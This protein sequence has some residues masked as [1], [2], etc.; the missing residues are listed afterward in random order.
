VCPQGR[1]P[2]CHAA[3]TLGGRRPTS[4][5]NVAAAS[6]L[7]DHPRTVDLRQADLLPHLDG[8][9]TSLAE[10]PAE[11]S[12]LWAPSG[13]FPTAEDR[14]VV[15]TTDLPWL[16][17]RACAGIIWSTRVV[18]VACGRAAWRRSDLAPLSAESG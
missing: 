16:T 9:R 4:S 18:R 3:P 8:W 1:H 17:V 12:N 2:T 13:L 10:T 11:P 15:G 5:V 6:S 7:L 14:G